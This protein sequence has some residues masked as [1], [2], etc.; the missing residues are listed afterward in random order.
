MYEKIAPLCLGALVTCKIY[1]YSVFEASDA[2]GE[3]I[4]RKE[5]ERKR[6]NPPNSVSGSSQL[7]G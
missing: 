1:K 4:E 6:N 5:K 2:G 3:K 7:S